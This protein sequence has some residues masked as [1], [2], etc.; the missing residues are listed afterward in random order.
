MKRKFITKSGKVF[1]SDYE[2]DIAPVLVGQYT[3]ENPLEIEELYKRED[4]KD[5]IIYEYNTNTY[6]NKDGLQPIIYYYIGAKVENPIIYKEIKEYDYDNPPK[7]PIIEVIL[8]VEDYKRKIYVQ[9]KNINCTFI[10]LMNSAIDE[11]NENLK[12]YSSNYCKDDGYC[13]IDF[14][15]NGGWKL[16]IEVELEYEP[17][18]KYISSVRLVEKEI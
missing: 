14:Y 9:M 16:D 8:Q 13:I 1:E 5:D 6:N 4:L 7:D 15:N 2:N 3:K 12:K 11:I 10:D 18:N 17:I